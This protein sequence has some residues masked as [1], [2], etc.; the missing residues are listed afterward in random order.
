M[1]NIT[2]ESLQFAKYE[3]MHIRI[4]PQSTQ[5]VKAPATSNSIPYYVMVV[6]YSN[7]ILK[8]YENTKKTQV[9]GVNTRAMFT[10][11]LTQEG[12]CDKA[13]DVILME[14]AT[15][16][17]NSYKKDNAD[18]KSEDR[19]WISLLTKSG[20][21]IKFELM[22]VDRHAGF[23]QFK[24]RHNNDTRYPEFKDKSNKF[25]K[26][27]IRIEKNFTSEF[28]EDLLKTNRTVNLSEEEWS[29]YRFE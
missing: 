4:K 12:I 9:P 5:F 6:L 25:E 26:P 13:D 2:S 15:Q 29:S 16:P 23:L 19:P 14:T 27:H 11:N 10:L 21:F 17:F 20:R 7:N 18:L 28:I 8:V 22:V 3:F 1:E 24:H